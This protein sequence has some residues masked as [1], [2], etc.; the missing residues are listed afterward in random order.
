MTR[1][2]CADCTRTRLT[3]EGRVRTCLFSRTEVDLLAAMRAGA[4]DEEI[5]NLWKGAHWAKLAG[6]GMDS[7]DFTQPQRPMSAIGG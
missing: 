3:A 7:D 6:H 4:S 5:A 2:F 1:P